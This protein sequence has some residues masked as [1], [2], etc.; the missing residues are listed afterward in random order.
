MST[1]TISNVKLE[2]I[3]AKA[4]EDLRQLIGEA[5]EKLLEAWASAELE[6]QEQE[7]KPVFRIGFAIV[8]DLD[9]DKM[10]TALTFG[11][12][13]KLSIDREI[14]DP[15]QLVLGEVISN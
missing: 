12:R 8:L 13:H 15:D 2:A 4:V 10:E 11:V 1:T 6:A 7:Q 3:T 9:K 5:E 14:P